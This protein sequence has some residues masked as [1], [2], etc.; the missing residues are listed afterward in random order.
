MGTGIFSSLTIGDLMK[1]DD[2][3]TARNTKKVLGLFSIL[4]GSGDKQSAVRSLTVV[5]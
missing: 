2:P 3:L 4:N 5:R 1:I